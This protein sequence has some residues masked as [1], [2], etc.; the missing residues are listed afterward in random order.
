MHILFKYILFTVLCTLTTVSANTVP[1]I[2]NIDT[3][4]L[5]E[6]SQAFI[7]GVDIYDADADSLTLSAIIDNPSLVNLEFLKSS[8]QIGTSINGEA[9]NNYS[10]WSVSL[11]ANGSIMA[12]GAPY[13]DT[14]QSNSGQVR[15]YKDINGIWE[16][17]G[18]AINGNSISEKSG[19][20]I[21]LSA[22]GSI[23]AIG[24]PYNDD[25]GEDSGH[26]RIYKNINNTWVQVGQ[27]IQGE[28]AYDYNGYA[29]SI[30][31]DGL[32][33][34]IGAY[35]NDAKGA[36][37]GYVR[38]YTLIN[39]TW[40]QIANTLEGEAQSDYSGYSVSLSSDS[41]TVAIGGRGND[42]NGMNS[43]HVRVYK[44]INNTWV[45]QGM[46]IDGENAQD[47]SGWA[48]SL[49]TD[50]SIVAIGAPYNDGNGTDS[51]HVRVYENIN[52]TWVQQ[53]IDIEGEALYDYSGWSV[54]LSADGKTLAI[55]AYGNDSYQ[56][57][58][59]YVRVYRN[60]NN[61]WVKRA[62]NIKGLYKND[63]SGNAI[64]LSS[65][66]STL[67]IGAYTN[68]GNGIDSGNVRV[69]TAIDALKITPNLNAYGESNISIKVSDAVL[70]SSTTFTLI[71]HAVDDAPVIDAIG[72]INTLED[73]HELNVTFSAMDIEGDSMSYTATSSDTSIATV[74]IINSIL[75]VSPVAN[76]YGTIQIE[77]IA[78]A[79]G[80]SS[81]QT[82]TFHI[83]PVND[84]PII[85]TN[86]N[87]IF[88]NPSTIF[89]LDF[90]VSDAEGDI[91]DIN[92]TS[93]DNSVA[94]VTRTWITPVYMADYT[95]QQL[96]ATIHVNNSITTNQITIN[97]SD[98]EFTTSKSF[99]LRVIANNEDE[100]TISHK[101][102]LTIIPIITYLL[103][104]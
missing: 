29:L 75:V 30:S 35:G 50:G 1:T 68:D 65:D 61:T 42:A 45:Q 66:A 47:N 78:S 101:N 49:N 27:D 69:Y 36:N 97:V 52:N 51:G 96:R 93:S 99:T 11:S 85:H 86:F 39:N 14:N 46:D 32:S 10:G 104:Q 6:D 83:V 9:L 72:D 43:G 2:A 95:S 103:S 48:V 73:I 63:N 38:I 92:V 16:Q 20:A 4:H 98:N 7:L 81:S 37:T 58:T 94:T 89:F 55:G 102:S 13:N 100:N 44:N 17:V 12:I 91:L 18:D 21:S 28:F 80:L 22:D 33:L 15:I 62:K 79:N 5:D 24:A 19:W 70:E 31:A 87:T 59:G 76:A 84:R 82:F 53:G 67:A 60:I 41:S 64:A 23:L 56:I 57:N 40:I 34:A 8:T 74:S 54:S 71:I 26:V 88:L 77:I 3:Q 25:N 90:N